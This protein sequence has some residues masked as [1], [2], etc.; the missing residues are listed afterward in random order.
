M[1]D[2]GTMYVDDSSYRYRRH[3]A[4]MGLNEKQM[5]WVQG[6]LNLMDVLR[7]EIKNTLVQAS[8]AFAKYELKLEQLRECKVRMEEL[9]EK[10]ERQGF[11]V[12]L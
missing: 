3:I 7:D 4:L 11:Q 1:A 5:A 10:I 8:E 12:L 6:L 2:A 9:E